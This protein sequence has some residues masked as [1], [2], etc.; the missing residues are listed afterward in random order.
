MSLSAAG[1]ALTVTDSASIGTLTV[2]ASAGIGGSLAVAGGITGASLSVS[3]I[4]TA[5][6]YAKSCPTGYVPV[7]GNP[8]FG[9]VDFCVMKYEAKNDGGG[10]AVSTATGTPYVLISQRTAQDKSLAASGHLISE[11]EWMTIATNALWVASNWTTGTVGSG[12]LFSGHNDN[13]PANALA[14]DTNDANGYF[15]ETNTGGTQRRT[16]TLS[17]GE[18]IWD[19]AGNV[20]E[21]TDA[22]IIGNEQPNDAVDGFAWHAFTA[23]TKWKDLNYANPTNRGWN[24]AQGLGQIYTDGTS[25]NNTLY[26]F[27]RGGNWSLGENA[28]AFALGLSSAP[29]ASNFSLGFRVAR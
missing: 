10:N 9:T 20:Y 2:V 7:P 15:G 21:W 26:G 12:A 16:L 1:T 27:V 11:A 25:T 4:V 17:N 18:V 23:I 14:A 8:K 19:F 5:A 28:G 29:T 13:A 3:G 24:S 22:W 6:S